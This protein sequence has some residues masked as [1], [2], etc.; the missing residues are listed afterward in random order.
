MFARVIVAHERGRDA[1]PVTSLLDRHGYETRCVFDGSTLLSVSENWRPRAA[2]MD[3]ALKDMPALEAGTVLRGR[4]GGEIHLVGFTQ[5]SAPELEKRALD[6]GFDHV[7]VDLADA[8]EIL[9][10]LAG[11]SAVLVARAQFASSQF[12]KTLTDYF[13]RRLEMHALLRESSH[14]RRNIVMLRRTV[15]TLQGCIDML[16]DDERAAMRLQVRKLEE[17]FRKLVES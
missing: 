8:A 12:A 17:H 14:R 2:V 7:V 4:Y 16:D 15:E 9:L 3:L 6:A 10:T 11:P 1:S 13:Y 5:P